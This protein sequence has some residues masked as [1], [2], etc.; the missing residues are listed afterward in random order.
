M[1]VKKERETRGEVINAESGLDRCINVCD[2]IG[3]G[4]RDLLRRGRAVSF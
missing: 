3:N 1:R 4:E 2:R